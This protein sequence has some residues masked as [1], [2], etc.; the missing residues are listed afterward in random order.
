MPAMPLISTAPWLAPLA[1]TPTT[2][3]AIDTMPS[4][5]PSTA[6]R[7]Q[8]ARAERWCS[9]CQRRIRVSTVVRHAVCHGRCAWKPAQAKVTLARLQRCSVELVRGGVGA[10]LPGS[11]YCR[12]RPHIADRLPGAHSLPHE[13]RVSGPSQ[14]KDVPIAAGTQGRTQL[15]EFLSSGARAPD[16]WRI[17]TEHEKFGFRTRRPAPAD[18]RRRARHR[19]AAQRPDALRLGAGRGDTAAR[20]SR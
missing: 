16:D 4:L 6:A 20:A 13:V 18:V 19:G 11:C 9:A 15:I 17:G 2:R 1:A 14:V 8:P 10:T 7:S 3:P 12:R 5:A